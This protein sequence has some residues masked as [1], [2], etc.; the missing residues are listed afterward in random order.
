MDCN[1]CLNYKP[2]ESTPTECGGFRVGQ[3]VKVSRITDGTVTIAG[4]LPTPNSRFPWGVWFREGCGSVPLDWLEWLEMVEKPKP[5]EPDR[6]VARVRPATPNETAQFRNPCPIHVGSFVRKGNT[7]YV[8]VESVEYDKT[9][10][11]WKFRD[12]L[13]AKH[14]VQG[15]NDGEAWREDL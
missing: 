15:P 2:K 5:P 9:D 6:D 10:N 13:G 4:F 7:P 12:H 1:T 3:K 11:L 14:I 8:K